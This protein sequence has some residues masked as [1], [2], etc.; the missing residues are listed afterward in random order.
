MKINTNNTENSVSVKMNNKYGNL[1]VVSKIYAYN[2]KIHCSMIVFA[3]ISLHL[4]NIL[5]LLSLI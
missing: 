4:S 1:N 2:N 5:K 3:F